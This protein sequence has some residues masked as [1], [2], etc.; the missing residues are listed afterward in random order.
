MLAW[1]SRSQRMASP[2][3]V[4][5]A[6]APWLAKKPVENRRTASRSRNSARASSSSTWMRMVPF[7][8]RE[9]VQ[10]E[11]YWRG[12][13]GGGPA[14]PPPPTE[15][16]VGPDHDFA[17]PAANHVVA[18]G[19]VNAAEVGVEALRTRIGTVPVF[20]AFLIKVSRQWKYGLEVYVPRLCGGCKCFFEREV[21]T[22]ALNRSCRGVKR[23]PSG[24]PRGPRTV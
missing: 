6:R 7:R 21:R 23:T 1:F 22:V 9:P 15:V 20:P 3:S 4:R 24:R 5:L 19:F 17:L 18:V 13:G 16:V 12:G 8:R 2:S 11:P 10:P 14:P